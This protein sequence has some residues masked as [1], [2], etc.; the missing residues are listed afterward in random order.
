MQ[1]MTDEVVPHFHNN[2]PGVPV[3]E[4]GAK[5]FICIG[6]HHKTIRMWFRPDARHCEVPVDVFGP[7]TIC[8]RHKSCHC[9]LLSISMSLLV[10]CMNAPPS[11]ERPAS[12][13]RLTTL[14]RKSIA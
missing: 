5:K 2:E 4:I 11:R 6:Y 10:I 3:I 1:I 12:F 13:H 8:T 9:A 14:T 7:N